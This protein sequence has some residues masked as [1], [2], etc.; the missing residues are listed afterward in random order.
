M[1][2]DFS[3]LKELIIEPNLEAAFE[4]LDKIILKSV[5]ENIIRFENEYLVYKAQHNEYSKAKRMNLLDPEIVSIRFSKNVHNLIELIQRLEKYYAK[6]EN[7]VQSAKNQIEELKNGEIDELK[8][9]LG[10]EFD[11]DANIDISDSI[12]TEISSGKHFSK[13]IALYFAGRIGAGKSTSCNKFLNINNVGYFDTTKQITHSG[14]AT[15]LSVF[16]LPGQNGELF[17]E[18]VSRVALGMPI[19]EGHVKYHSGKSNFEKFKYYKWSSKHIIDDER[20]FNLFEWSKFAEIENILPD[21]I[22][23]V[24]GIG[25]GQLFTTSD[26]IF[27]CTLL[28]S[29][30]DKKKEDKL[31]FL[32]NDLGEAQE[33]MYQ[34]FREEIESCYNMVFEKESFQSPIIF[35]VNALSG[36]GFIDFIKYLC[37]ILP[38]D[39]IGQIKELFHQDFKEEVNKHLLNKFHDNNI[40]IASK[41]S[42]FYPYESNK[43]TSIFESSIIAIIGLAKHFLV[44]YEDEKHKDFFNTVQP[45]FLEIAKDII[46]EVAIPKTIRV[47]IIKEK[48]E[49]VKI[50]SPD[51]DEV[52]TRKMLDD[53]FNKSNNL[54]ELKHA[55]HNLLE[56]FNM[57]TTAEVKYDA[58]FS[59]EEK[60][61]YES[62]IIKT[63]ILGQKNISYTDY[64]PKIDGKKKAIDNNDPKY[65]KVWCNAVEPKEPYKVPNAVTGYI[66]EEIRVEYNKAGIPFISFILGCGN[67]LNT[68]INE[69]EKNSFDYSDIKK[70]VELSINEIRSKLD[71]N[72][73]ELDINIINNAKDSEAKINDIV[74]SIFK[75]R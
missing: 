1:I 18:N 62:T 70:R 72:K 66:D 3:H 20:E 56:E 51:I 10:D 42:K 19:I 61:I 43:N 65:L 4:Y 28:E 48:I 25:K 41:L 16:D 31:L 39:T 15:G 59:F 52:I 67:E 47:P 69:Y 40:V 29:L 35:S 9:I 13:P 33:E 32:F 54:S 44:N 12:I 63:P 2:A 22:I 71:S 23:Y 53:I 14:F 58:L 68:F 45:V 26:R 5:D 64:K 27:I 8:N 73:T 24:V 17:F 38:S 11:I 34:I 7:D 55:A 6:Y 75:P 74:S 30:K 60:T 37:G 57:T 49:N 50:T 46:K 21:I 36:E